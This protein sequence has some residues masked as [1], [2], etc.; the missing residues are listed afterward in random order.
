MPVQK[1]EVVI[2]IIL[3]LLL[4]V[5]G[6][7]RKKEETIR[8]Y[9]STTIEPFIVKASED[10]GR[11]RNIDFAVKA[12]GSRSGIDSLIAGKC[13]IVMSSMEILPEQIEQAKKNG[14]QVKP[15]LIGYDIIIPIVHPDNSVSDISFDLLKKVFSGQLKNWKEVG[16]MDAP[17]EVVDRAS[18][19]GTYSVW[20]HYVALEEVTDT[21]LHATVKPTNSSVLSY[22]AEN[23]HA[24]GYVSAAY[25]NPEVKALTLDGVAM[26][27]NDARLSEY[28]LKRPLFLYVDEEQFDGAVKL[29]VVY[30]IINERGKELLRESGFFYTSWVG[31]Y[32]PELP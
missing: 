6:C 18:S 13:R 1:K 30:L 21:S 29:F 32:H 26:K 8:I 24:I 15:F 31:D 12:V 28:H 22:I 2:A 5:P 14:I 25:L 16:G 11:K 17:I 7:T 9:G 27:D 20:H 19:S 3:F 23:Q 4:I 10:F